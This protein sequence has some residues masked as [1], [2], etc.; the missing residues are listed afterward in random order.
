MGGN[1]VTTIVAAVRTFHSKTKQD[2]AA[3]AVAS[4]RVPATQI[5]NMGAKLV[6]RLES[7]CRAFLLDDGTADSLHEL[8][9]VM[10]TEDGIPEMPLPATKVF[11]H[12]PA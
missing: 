10:M 9:L 2:N 8:G 3:L 12:L 1:T 11:D 5:T 4:A 6:T 7:R